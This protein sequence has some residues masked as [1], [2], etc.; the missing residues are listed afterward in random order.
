MDQDSGTDEP[1]LPISKAIQAV[2]DRHGVPE[3][4]RLGTLVAAAGMSYQQ[5]RRRMT[6]ETSWNVDELKRL[7]SHFGEPLFKLLGTLVDDVG[8]QATLVVGG[9]SLPCSIWP[10]AMAPPRS[11]IGPLVAIPNDAGDD[12]TV[13]P[14]ADT[15]D[16][17]AYEV[18]RLVYEAAPPRRIAV[19]DEDDDLAASIVEFLRDKGLDAVS[20][21]SSEQLRAALDSS[22][23]E[24]FIL[25]WMPAK[26]STGDLL[27]EV[28]ARN[29][30]A[31]VIILAARIEPGGAQEDE[32][33]KAISAH[34]AQLYEKPP[35]MLALFNALE[36]G[37]ATAP[38]P[39]LT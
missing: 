11:R 23:F 33:A 21:R 35:R 27:P 19:V 31:P 13:V 14:V 34:R 39:L 24:G 2:L 22:R 1:K 37:F 26:G 30:G 36:L 32:L 17:T 9:V 8:Q 5:V 25:D 6:G 10:G 20:Y 29:P 28:R 12:W 7:A 15:G 18:R 4:Q 16:R 38:R 3:R